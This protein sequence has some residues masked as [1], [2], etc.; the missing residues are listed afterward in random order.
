MKA[1]VGINGF[2]RI[3]R[4]MFRVALDQQDIEIVHVNNPSDSATLAYLLKYDSNYGVLDA[5]VKAEEDAIIVNGKRVRYTQERDPGKVPWGETNVDIVLE[6]S[7]VFNDVESGS[8][9]MRDTVKK[10]IFTAAAKGVDAT[11]CMGVN[12]NTYDAKKHNYISNASCTTNCMA[13]IVKVLNDNLKVKYGLMTTIH[14]YTNDQNILDLPHKDLRRSRAAAINIIPTT[15]N[16]AYAVAIVIP[17]LKDK[18]NGLSIRVPTPTMS[19]LDFV[20][21]TEKS[22]TIEEVNALMQ[23]AASGPMK[24]ILSVSNEPLVSIDYKKSSYSA[25]VDSLSTMVM[26]KNMVKVV[27]WYDNEWGY[28]C[29]VIDLTKMVASQM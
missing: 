5:E 13:P 2:G 4:E 18:L 28:S 26:E 1:R 24:G 7:G 9:H 21:E 12:E 14:S 25:I 17:E 20:C 19:L 10:V 6:A 29:R 27:A 23:K 8:K 11:L 22:T 16:A 15:T 3:G